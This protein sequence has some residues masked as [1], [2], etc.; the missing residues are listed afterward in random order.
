LIFPVSA[1]GDRSAGDPGVP[2]ETIFVASNGWHSTIFVSRS[3][4]TAADLP[5]IAD[6]P[7][8]VYIGFGWGDAEYFPRRDPGVLTL[9]SAALLPTPSVIHVT[10]LRINPRNAYPHDEV[11]SLKVSREDLRNLRQFLS[12]SFDRGGLSRGRVVAPGLNP[13]SLFYNAKGEFHLF[14]TCN[15]W[16]ARGLSASGVAIEPQGL[17]RAEDIMAELRALNKAHPG[18]RLR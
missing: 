15:S 6:F 3:A 18:D 12:G 7:D 4:L 5:E 10:G 8:A 13:Q 17:V 11:V 1:S 9:L 16:T 14:N 2:S